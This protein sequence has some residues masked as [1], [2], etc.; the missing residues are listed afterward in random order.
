VVKGFVSGSIASARLQHPSI[1]SRAPT[2]VPFPSPPLTPKEE[3]APVLPG[4]GKVLCVQPIN[5]DAITAPSMVFR[6]TVIENYP[7]YE[8]NPDQ[9]LYERFAR[10]GYMAS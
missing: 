3:F 1:V 9:L 5:V 2:Y 6:D 7:L 4:A 10:H 8:Q